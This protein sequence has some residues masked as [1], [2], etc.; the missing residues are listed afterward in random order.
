MQVTI[1]KAKTQLSK[2][3]AAAS[4]G[5]EV[6]IANGATPVAK[7]I[8]LPKPSFK[9]GVLKGKLLGDGPDFFEPM[10]ESELALW[11]GGD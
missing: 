1:H 8:A 3:I 10:S 4:A 5:E 7:L 6:I 11:E 9:V 2:L